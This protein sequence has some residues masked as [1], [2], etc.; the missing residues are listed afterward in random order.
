M[1]GYLLVDK[2]QGWTSFDVVAKVRGILRRQTGQKQIKVGHS[3][4]LDP[5]A[6]G[7]LII[8]VGTYTKRQEEFMSLDKIYDA[9]LRLGGTSTTGDPEGEITEVSDRVPDGEEVEAVLKKFTGVIEQTPPIY[10]AIKIAG[11]KAYELA[12]AGKP[13]KLKSRKVTIYEIVKIDYE[14]PRL[15]FVS[16][17]SS[18]TYIRSLA[19]SIG[20]DLGIGAYLDEL[21]R[22]NIGRFGLPEAVSAEDLGDFETIKNLLKTD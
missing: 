13:V 15:S 7:L 18:G 22:L 6:T 4:T 1:N 16:R 19:A 5:F 8:L 14:Y 17:V 11:R 3:G 2:P 9:V 21:R 10:S 12:R 20:E